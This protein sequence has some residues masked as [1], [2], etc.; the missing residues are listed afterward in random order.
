LSIFLDPTADSILLKNSSVFWSCVIA[1][2]QSE[3]GKMREEIEEWTVSTLVQG[4]GIEEQY[5]KQY[6][7]SR[8]PNEA[9]EVEDSAVAADDPE[10]RVS[11]RCVRRLQ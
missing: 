10:Q 2:V 3:E 6:I 8:N 5:E 7:F 4:Q 1:L 9:E 11:S